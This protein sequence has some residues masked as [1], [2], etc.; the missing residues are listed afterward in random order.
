MKQSL[1]KWG[2]APLVAGALLAPTPMLAQAIR[3]KS[4]GWFQQ[5]LVPDIL[6]VSDR[7]QVSLKGQV[8]VVRVV[9]EEPRGSGKLTGVDLDVSV[10]S[11]GTGT[12]NGVMWLE[13]GTWP[14][15]GNFTR[16]DG[17]WEMKFNGLLHVDGSIEFKVTG[18][19]IGGTIDG[20]HVKGTT[21]RA[22]S[23]LDSP[24]L[25]SGIMTAVGHD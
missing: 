8:H 22:S 9:S 7:G 13:V 14:A 5:V 10:N 12:F 17:V 15:G 3:F 21:T 24:Y 4:T 19:G 6:C 16:T 1:F 18:V 23:S 20:L 11:D 2:I 25:I